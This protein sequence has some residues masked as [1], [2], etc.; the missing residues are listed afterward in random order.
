MHASAGGG[1]TSLDPSPPWETGEGSLRDMGKH[2]F[3]PLPF[4]T[5]FKSVRILSRRQSSQ[6]RRL[7]IFPYLLRKKLGRRDGQIRD[8]GGS[9][10]SS[11]G[12]GADFVRMMPE[13]QA[14]E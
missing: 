8:R 1:G 9:P 2:G 11:A 4:F 6:L 7:P 14:L 13:H 12:G 5:K 10:E 3:L